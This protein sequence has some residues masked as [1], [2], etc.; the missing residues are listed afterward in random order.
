[1]YLG[2]PV[3]ILP[4]PGLLIAFVAA[5][6][7]GGGGGSGGNGGA[8][9]MNGDQPKAEKMTQHRHSYNNNPLV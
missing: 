7:G 9:T 5:A 6:L 3:Q 4:D 8:G 2:G 1:M